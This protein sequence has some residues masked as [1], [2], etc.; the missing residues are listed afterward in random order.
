MLTHRR[1]WTR[2]P[3]KKLFHKLENSIQTYINYCKTHAMATHY[4]G[5]GDTS[6]EN[7]ETQD[8]DNDSQDKIQEENIVQQ[9]ICK[10]EHLRQTVE[11]RDNDPRDAIHQLEQKLN[12]LTLTLHPPSEPIEEVLDK[13][14]DTSC[15]S[16]KKTSLESSLLQ[17]I[18]TL[19][20]QDSSQLEDWL[21]DTETASE[22]TGESRM[23][24]AQ[25]KSRG[26]VRTLISEA[27]TSQKTWEEIKDSLCL[28][29]S[30]RDIHTSI[31]TLWTS[32]SQT[33]NL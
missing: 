4:S 11:D 19:N 6:M 3:I 2:S 25:A 21:T 5:I 16:Q 32:N 31:T 18:P 24:L 17:D 20:G 22:L 30:N 8:M 7:P 15:N 1:L 28:K 29:I 12:Q 27:L 26:L 13:Y 9:L 14:T 33:K 23:K 10:T